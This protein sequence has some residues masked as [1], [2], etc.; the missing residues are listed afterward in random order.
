MKV[1]IGDLQFHFLGD[2]KLVQFSLLQPL[3]TIIISTVA[4]NEP[5]P[6]GANF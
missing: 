6:S 5:G 3:I 2:F 1:Y 4:H